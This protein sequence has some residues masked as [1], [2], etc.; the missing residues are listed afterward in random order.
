MHLLSSYILKLFLLL[1][2]RC[3]IKLVSNIYILF[4]FLPLNVFLIIQTVLRCL[5]QH[6]IDNTNMFALRSNAYTL[7][8]ELLEGWYI[9][10]GVD[11][12]RGNF[13]CLATSHDRVASNVEEMFKSGW[14]LTL[15]MWLYFS[16]AVMHV[17][18]PEAL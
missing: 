15:I 7:M 16:L 12:H 9:A 13:F 1:N 8:N 4:D 11:D 17:N 3:I 10:R 2:L 18:F 14:W 6:W 5:I